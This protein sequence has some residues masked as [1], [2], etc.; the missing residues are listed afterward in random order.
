[1]HLS[2]RAA[3]DTDQEFAF[4]VKQAAFG[5]YV[6]RVWGWDDDFQRRFHDR[7]WRLHRP[8]IITVDDAR[9][10]NVMVFGSP[11]R[12]PRI[13]SPNIRDQTVWERTYAR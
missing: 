10:P 7:D 1:M 8:V 12:P 3:S 11:G 2:L 4:R 5:A 9:C 13:T 6:E